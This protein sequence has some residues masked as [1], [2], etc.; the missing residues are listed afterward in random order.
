VLIE[1]GTTQSASFNENVDAIP[2]KA[3]E[4][5]RACRVL[6]VDDDYLV[7]AQLSALLGISQ[8]GVKAAATGKWSRNG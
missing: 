1:R 7:R 5:R 4:T 2:A 8:Y 3:L 6:V